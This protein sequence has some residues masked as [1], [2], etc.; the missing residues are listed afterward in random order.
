MQNVE[1]TEEIMFTNV[2]N[3]A[4]A[5]TDIKTSHNGAGYGG[6]CLK[7]HILGGRDKGGQHRQS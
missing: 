1:K 3:I 5:S 7:S 2:P 4:K 6:T